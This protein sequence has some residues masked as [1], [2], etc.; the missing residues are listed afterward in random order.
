M[1]T[2]RADTMFRRKRYLGLRHPDADKNGYEKWV[3]F[4]TD[5]PPELVEELYLAQKDN[6]GTNWDGYKK[7]PQSATRANL[8]RSALL[9]YLEFVNPEQEAIDST[10]EEDPILYALPNWPE[11]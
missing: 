7:K 5:V 3:R 10:A 8:V 1:E 11:E 9:L 6:M 4:T 2:S